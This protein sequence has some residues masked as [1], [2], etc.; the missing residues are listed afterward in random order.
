MPTSW[1]FSA[2]VVDLSLPVTKLWTLPFPLIMP[3]QTQHRSSCTSRILT[4]QE[5]IHSIKTQ[6]CSDSVKSTAVPKTGVALAVF[7]SVGWVFLRFEVSSS[8]ISV[9]GILQESGWHHL[10][11]V[12]RKRMFCNYIVTSSDMLRRLQ[13]NSASGNQMAW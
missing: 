2:W 6:F 9:Q 10:A 3:S 13:R 7:C 1:K 4:V 5:K 8:V 11:L 12:P